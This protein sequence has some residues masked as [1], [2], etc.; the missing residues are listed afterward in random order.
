MIKSRGELIDYCLRALGAPVLEINV[1]EEQVED[2]I[3]EALQYYQDF[4][5]DA[6]IRNYR[7][8]Q[9]TQQDIENRFITL[10]E[11]VIFITRIF[12]L[13]SSNPFTD[14]G[15][16]D[17]DYQVHLDSI[18]NLN[19]TGGLIDYTMM[20]QYM[21]LIDITLNTETATSFNRHMNRLFLETNFEGI[22]PGIFMLI[23]LYETVDP[24]SFV[25]IYN[26]RWLKKY[27]IALIQRQWG[28][29]LI[30]FGGMQLPGGVTID[31]QT[32]FNE[33]KE[34]IEKLEEEIRSQHEL[35]ADFIV[36]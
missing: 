15:L 8:H 24:E 11:N 29:N 1:D 33:A 34:S 13:R 9:I 4:H 2:R 19:Y 7:K 36:G 23:D 12:P 10:P 25:N 14:G 31:G 21:R 18:Y 28:M 35:P 17:V 22:E 30:K 3:D 20:K 6:I 32:I 27:C 26:D 16:F 5:S